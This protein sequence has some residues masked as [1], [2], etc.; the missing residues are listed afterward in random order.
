MTETNIQIKHN[1]RSQL[2]G[3]KPADYLQTWSRIWTRHFRE[4]IQ[5]TV[6]AERELGASKMQVALLQLGHAPFYFIWK[7]WGM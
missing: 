3:G 6:R 1:G 5:L 7:V 2:A 4:Q